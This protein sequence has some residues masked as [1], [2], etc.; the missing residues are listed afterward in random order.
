MTWRDVQHLIVNTAKMSGLHGRDIKS[1]GAGKQC[2][3][4]KFLVF[5]KLDKNRNTVKH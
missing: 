4:E 3:W 2:M 1:N 5:A